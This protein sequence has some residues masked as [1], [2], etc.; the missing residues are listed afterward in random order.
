MLESAIPGVLISITKIDDGN[1][2]ILPLVNF[3]F[4][5]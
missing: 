4:S 1:S 2:L 5:F 3:A